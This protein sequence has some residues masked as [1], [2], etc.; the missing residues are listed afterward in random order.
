M[1][2]LVIANQEYFKTGWQKKNQKDKYKILWK[3]MSLSMKYIT[4]NRMK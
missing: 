4:K 3:P 2:I 1:M